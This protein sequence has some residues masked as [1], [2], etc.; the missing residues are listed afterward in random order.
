MFDER[1]YRSVA[2]AAGAD[3][4]ALGSPRRHRLIDDR[5]G[6]PGKREAVHPAAAVKVAVASADEIEGRIEIG[7]RHR[8]EHGPGHQDIA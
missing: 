6:T 7:K 1:R 8:F 5:L 2:A 4:R 3:P